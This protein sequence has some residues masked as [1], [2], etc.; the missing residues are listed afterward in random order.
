MIFSQ[1]QTQLEQLKM[2]LSK[3]QDEHFCQPISHL[4]NATI[5]QH[6]R[7]IIELLQ[8]LIEGKKTGKVD[9]INRVRDLSIETDR[10]NAIA[11]ISILTQIIRGEDVDLN[12]HT[13][14]NSQEFDKDVNTSFFREIIYN[15]EHATHHLALIKVGLIEMKLYVFEDTFGFADSTLKYKSSL[16]P[17]T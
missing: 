11:H 7:H 1:L 12:L 5:G 4:G 8:C 3:I 9:Y 16:V 13:E 17:Q 15:T 2:V 10:T 14:H 6:T